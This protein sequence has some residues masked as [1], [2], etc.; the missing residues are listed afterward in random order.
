MDSVDLS[1]FGNFDQKF[2]YSKL[3]YNFRIKALVICHIV[4]MSLKQILCKVKIWPYFE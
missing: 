2:L 3:S 1:S 4:K